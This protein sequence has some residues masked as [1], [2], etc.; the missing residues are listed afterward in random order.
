MTTFLVLSFLVYS[1]FCWWV[2]FRDGAEILEGWKAAA[3][4]DWAA[5]ALTAS[6]LRFGVGISWAVA[7]ILGLVGYYS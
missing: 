7:V 1:A 2:V 5:I 3:L 6:E 4:F